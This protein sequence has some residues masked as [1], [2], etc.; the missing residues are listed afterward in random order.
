MFKIK[1]PADWVPSEGSRPGLQAAVF[2]VCLHIAL[3]VCSWKE[4]ELSSSL[5]RVLIA[6]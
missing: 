1:A 3:P 5:L 4:R 2:L 6:S